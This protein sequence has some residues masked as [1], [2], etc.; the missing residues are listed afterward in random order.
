MAINTTVFSGGRIFNG[1]ELLTDHY[2][3]FVDGVCT[4]VTA[5]KPPAGEFEVVNLNDDILSTGYTDLQVNG[6]GGVMFNDDPCLRNLVTI[7]QAHR[8]PGTVCLLPTLITDTP[9][10]TVAAI[11]A[12]SQALEENV[13]GIAGLHLEGPHLSIEK[14]GAHDGQLIRP[15]EAYDLQILLHAAEKLP[16]LMITVAPENVSKQQVSALAEAG[17][18]VALGHTGASYSTCVEY[19]NAGASC[20]THLFN[21]MSQLNSREPGLAGAAVDCKGLYAG[22]IADGVHVHPAAIRAAW[23]GSGGGDKFYLVTDAMAP[24][25]TEQTSFTL[26]GRTV[27]RRDGRLTLADGTLAGADL[28]LTGAIRFMHHEVGVDLESVLR[29]ATTIPASVLAN[30]EPPSGSGLTGTPIENM[31]RISADLQSV[32]PLVSP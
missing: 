18:L 20:V 6:G 29:S 13:A 3:T 25:G 24:A 26:N 8:K 17:A 30:T 32:V 12:V 15:M 23:N 4:D 7:A 16:C 27:Y 5:G 19:H 1:V 10:V 31:I 2:A 11:D 9:D 21:A 28:D 14:K 22:L